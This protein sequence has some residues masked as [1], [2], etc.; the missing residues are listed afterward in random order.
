MLGTKK[1]LFQKCLLLTFLLL[2]LAGCGQRAAK[3]PEKPK[4]RSVTPAVKVEILPDP[5]SDRIAGMTDEQKV[6]QLFW[7][8][9]PESGAEAWIAEYQ[10]AGLILFGRDFEGRTP[11]TLRNFLG[12]CQEAALLPLLVGVDE[13]GGTV[14]RVSGREAFRTERFRS[15]QDVFAAGGWEEVARDTAAK[16]ALLR[17]LGIN[18]NLAPVADVSTDPSDFIY[19]R[20]FGQGP[21]E[22]ARYAVSVVRQMS[23]DGVGSVLKHFPGYGGNGDTHT[24]AVFDERPLSAFR[25]RDLVPFA[26]AIRAGA[27]AVLV[28]HNVAVCMDAERPASLSPAVHALLRD[29]LDF[30]GVSVT[31]DMA[32]GAVTQYTD[33]ETAAVLAVNAG[34]D[35]LISS[36]L[37]TQYAAVLAAV[38]SGEIPQQ[39]LHE[40]V[41]RVLRWKRAIGIWPEAQASPG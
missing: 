34:N 18:V 15:P 40:A 6:G 20:A 17:S 1:R 27:D 41:Y 33:T 29:E 11:E 21:E 14:T 2:A 37:P 39:R 22:T 12:S 26:D 35:L 5:V 32:M 3:A 10:P 9:C 25:E 30:E 19:A 36:D 13:E 8:R 16:D 24:G 31:D 7:A 38:R 23:N 28:S 4:S